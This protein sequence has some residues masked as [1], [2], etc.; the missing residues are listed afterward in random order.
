MLGQLSVD[1]N[2][3]NSHFATLTASRR[4]ITSR[5]SNKNHGKRA[6]LE[7]PPAPLTNPPAS[8]PWAVV[9]QPIR[10][11][12]DQGFST[13]QARLTKRSAVPQ[14]L[15]WIRSQRWPGFGEALAPPRR[16]TS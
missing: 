7:K 1:G 12:L 6:N 16:K 5:S 3:A 13:V 15:C 2:S 4:L 10:T 11:L 9:S 8:L 14:L